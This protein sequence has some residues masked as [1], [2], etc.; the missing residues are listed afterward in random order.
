MVSTFERVVLPRLKTL[1]DKVMARRAH[2][3]AQLSALRPG[4]ETPSRAPEVPGMIFAIDGES[5][6]LEAAMLVVA[7]AIE[8][9]ESLKSLH[10]VKLAASCSKSQQ[11]CDVSPVYR[12]LKALFSNWKAIER[13]AP[14]PAYMELIDALLEPLETPSKVVFTRFFGLL[15]DLLSQAFR[16]SNIRQGWETSGLS[17]L[18]H[19]RILAQNP[20][21]DE[22]PQARVDAYL[23]AIGKLAPVVGA[24]GQ[25]TDSQISEAV[26][27]EF[28]NGVPHAP[29]GGP[30]VPRRRRRKELHEMAINR[31]RALL[32]THATILH[33]RERVAASADDGG[34]LE[35]RQ[36]QLPDNHKE[37]DVPVRRSR[38]RPRSRKEPSE[39][40]AGVSVPTRVQ[41]SRLARAAAGD[42]IACLWAAAESDTES[43]SETDEDESESE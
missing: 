13:Q 24:A 15:H 11:P 40:D 2:A 10:L 5:S 12:S 25:L 36:L 43:E 23:A 32:V 14:R 33:T 17:P 18:S 41:P 4:E 9:D 7:N 16:D 19:K 38:G 31:R 1:R 8:L 42:L 3:A 30:A 28:A 26:G 21:S 39:A 6:C 37:R 27:A 35:V 20:G 34:D 22:W 29:D